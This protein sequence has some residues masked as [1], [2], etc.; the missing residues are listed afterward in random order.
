MTPANPTNPSTEH[1][2]AK[3]ESATGKQ[4]G[5]FE[6][7]ARRTAVLTGRPQA[8]LIAFAIVIVWGVTGPLFHYSD[9]WQLV[10]NTGTTIV[11]FLMVFLIQQSQNRDTMA[12]QV[13]LAEI[14]IALKGA[15]NALANAEDLSERELEALHA[16]YAQKAKLTL[17][18]LN[19]R[20]AHKAPSDPS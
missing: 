20:E 12:I 15:H 14:I 3:P 7:F 18:R 1:R 11:T 2:G 5:W 17:E 6:R 10:I 16:D 19:E 4:G 9:T 13:K 8:F